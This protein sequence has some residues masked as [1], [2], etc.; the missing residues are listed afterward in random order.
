MNRPEMI[1]TNN[2][3]IW[4][5]ENVQEWHRLMYLYDMVY[6]YDRDMD[7]CGN[8]HQW[9]KMCNC[10][11]IN[12]NVRHAWSCMNA[13]DRW[14]YV[15]VHVWQESMGMIWCVCIWYGLHDC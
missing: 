2:K 6:I 3:V 11:M 14:I 13:I 5:W 7:L 9:S 4:V 8:L 12:M 1:C 15:D 10:M